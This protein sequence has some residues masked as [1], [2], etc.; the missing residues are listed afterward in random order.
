[1]LAI[2]AAVLIIGIIYD[3]IKL[4]LMMQNRNQ[5]DDNNNGI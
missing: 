3:D 2:A 4:K 5:N 1:V